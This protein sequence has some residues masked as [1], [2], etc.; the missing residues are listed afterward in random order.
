MVE[1]WSKHAYR[2]SVQFIYLFAVLI[3]A[4]H[5]SNGTWQALQSSWSLCVPKPSAIGNVQL[6][7]CWIY[8]GWNFLSFPTCLLCSLFTFFPELTGFQ[9]LASFHLSGRWLTNCLKFPTIGLFSV[10]VSS[11]TVLW[12]YNVSVFLLKPNGFGAQLPDAYC[13]CHQALA[14]TRCLL[15]LLLWFLVGYHYFFSFNWACSSVHICQL[16][17][18]QLL[19]VY[20]AYLSL[21]LSWLQVKLHYQK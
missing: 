1:N 20:R 8:F 2:L 17:L 4:L 3:Q 5:I 14:D 10:P 9:Q 11:Q 18:L 15:L 6:A 7:T 13:S 21:W 16:P 12:K 19:C